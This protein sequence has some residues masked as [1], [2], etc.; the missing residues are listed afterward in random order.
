MLR[1]HPEIPTIPCILLI[2]LEIKGMQKNWINQDEVLLPCTD[3]LPPLCRHRP[4]SMQPPR[5]A[6]SAFPLN[7]CIHPLSVWRRAL[8]A[9]G[10][11]HRHTHCEL[12][13]L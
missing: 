4:P 13:C 12:G 11:A 3:V 5:N 6:Q 2:R 8:A 9:A 1:Y 7:S 10:R